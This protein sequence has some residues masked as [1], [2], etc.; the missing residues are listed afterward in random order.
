MARDGSAVGVLVASDR[1][2]V[3]PTPTFGQ[4][5]GLQRWLARH[6]L[7]LVLVAPLF[8]YVI[9]FMLVPVAQSI[10]LSFTLEGAGQPTFDNYRTVINRS[11]FRDA[12][13]NTLGISVIGVAMEMTVGITIA[14]MLARQFRGRGLFRSVVLVPLGVPTIVAGAAMLYFIGF[15]GY[16]NEILLDL[17]IIDVPVYWQQSGL[18]GMFAIA[19]ADLWKT[20]PLVVL[21]LLAGLESIPGDVYEA[22]SVDGADGWRRF[23]DHTIP[24]LMPSITMALILRVIDA[25]RI[26][27]IALVLAGQ[28]IPVMS[29]FVYFD[30]QAGSINTASAAAVILLLMILVFVVAYLLLVARRTEDVR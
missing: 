22:A 30:Y 16:L 8:L 18:R 11:Q 14:L 2:I 4:P 24:L 27:D 9:F 20:T 17:G 3:P 29:S 13:V 26:F 6:W 1:A 15:N 23:W 12:F 10:Y 21:I 28:A 19:L 7:D 5:A 25:F